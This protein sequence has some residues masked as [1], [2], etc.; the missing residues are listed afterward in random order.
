[1]T[2]KRRS[3]LYS[4]ALYQIPLGSY[5]SWTKRSFMSLLPMLLSPYCS[6][7][8]QEQNSFLRLIVI[9]Y[10]RLNGVNSKEH[11]VFREL[12]R[13][14]HYFEKIKAAESAETRQ[15]VTLDKAAAGRFIKNA[16]VSRTRWAIDFVSADFNVRL[17][18]RDLTSIWQ[19][20]AKRKAQPLIPDLNGFLRNRNSAAT[21]EMGQEPSPQVTTP[22]PTQSI[23]SLLRDH[24]WRGWKCRA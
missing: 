3:S 23:W 12:T 9:A 10:L 1:M 20:K 21:Q 14:K 13:V 7:R 17:G 11:P 18:I 22:T 4:K 6:V 8:L 16:L 24:V 15:N 2:S 19:S 5:L